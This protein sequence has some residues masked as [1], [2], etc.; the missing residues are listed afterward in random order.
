MSNRST[1]FTAFPSS[2]S[3]LA[4][5][6]LANLNHNLA[7]IRQIAPNTAVMAML[8]ANAY[9]H[10]QEHIALHLDK[11]DIDAIAV[12]RQWEA[13]SLLEQKVSTPIVILSELITPDFLSFC[14]S[15]QLQPVVHDKHGLE[16]V[17]HAINKGKP[18]P[19]Y[20]WLK[21]NTGMNRLGLNE[22]DYKAAINL[23]T[24]KSPNTKI[25]VLTHFSSADECDKTPTE[26]QIKCFNQ[27]TN[28]DAIEKSL[29]NSAGIL[30]MP[31]AHADWVRPG[32]MLYGV[33]PLNVETNITAQLKP[34][35]ELTSRV[36]AIHTL[37]D[38]DQVGYNRTWTSSG[39]RTIATVSIGYGDGYP[40]H[41]K[42][43]T[44]VLIHGERAPLVGRVSM[45]MITI[46]ITDVKSDVNRG[47]TVT[48]WGE[49]LSVNE[50]A[51]HCDTIGYELLTGISRRV[52]YHYLARIT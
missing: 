30:S 13:E 31:Q 50:V 38:G 5:I 26:Q 15:K 3:A 24:E 34:V 20:L 2:V 49:E 39:N 48:L 19:E 47:D 23:I 18:L 27:A 14:S 4:Q 37:K 25:R 7:L 33:N 6:N 51:K 52:K 11:T 29:A 46:D 21:L 42:N 1:Q 32:I 35:M 45:D 12:A 36:I 17:E 40:R 44:P 8:K 16:S 9:G 10:G 41:A 28:T 22:I 43:G